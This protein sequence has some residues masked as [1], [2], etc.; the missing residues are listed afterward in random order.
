MFD[1]NAVEWFYV[2]NNKSIINKYF[3]IMGKTYKKTKR[4]K[5]YS[6]KD[7]QKRKESKRFEKYKRYED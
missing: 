1:R 6:A 3:L 5:E 2:W 7:E 4:N